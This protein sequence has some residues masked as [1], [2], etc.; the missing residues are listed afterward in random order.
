MKKKVLY[1]LILTFQLFLE[2]FKRG[3]KFVHVMQ[4]YD[5]LSFKRKYILFLLRQFRNDRHR[6]I[7]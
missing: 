3:N 1:F 5:M 6:Q 2:H 7:L 4:H